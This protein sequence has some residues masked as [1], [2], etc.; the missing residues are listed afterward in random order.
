MIVEREKTFWDGSR[1]GV[2]VL[3]RVLKRRDRAYESGRGLM[4]SIRSMRKEWTKTGE[5]RRKTVDLC[6][7]R[8]SENGRSKKGEA[9]AERDGDQTRRRG[10]DR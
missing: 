3:R 4:A 1:R 10:K 7:K 9:E 6:G 8:R 5:H 2:S